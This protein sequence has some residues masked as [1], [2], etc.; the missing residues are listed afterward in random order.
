MSE[1]VQFLSGYLL[2]RTSKNL[3][4]TQSTHMVDPDPLFELLFGL[5]IAR[6]AVATDH[7]TSVMF[8]LSETYNHR[9]I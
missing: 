4:R 9:S 7:A 3:K 8:M 6:H 1:K 2:S 5:F